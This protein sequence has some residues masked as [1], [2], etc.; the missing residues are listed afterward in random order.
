MTLVALTVVTH[1]D[2]Q[3][4]KLGCHLLGVIPARQ[5]EGFLGVCVLEQSTAHS[6]VQRARETKM[7]AELRA[8][9]ETELWKARML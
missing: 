3:K 5:M 9:G 2:S 7:K 6:A 1:W 4:Q 8:G